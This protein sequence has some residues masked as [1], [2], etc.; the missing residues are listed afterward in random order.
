M[1]AET[2]GAP[3]ERRASTATKVSANLT[4]ESLIST[5]THNE[6]LCELHEKHLNLRGH[7]TL[8]PESIPDP[9]FLEAYAT[10]GPSFPRYIVDLDDWEE[11]GSGVEQGPP[12]PEPD[13]PPEALRTPR[14]LGAQG[15]PPQSEEERRAAEGEVPALGPAARFAQAVVT[16]GPQSL[17]TRAQRASRALQALNREPANSETQ[18]DFR[19]R[20]AELKY[21]ERGPLSNPKDLAHAEA[22]LAAVLAKRRR[23]ANAQAAREAHRREME[24]ALGLALPDE[25]T[26]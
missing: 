26:T 16:T 20:L 15:W 22:V 10:A 2:A 18:D 17:P 19:E 21:H 14:G 6:R 12:E 3:L 23:Q 1:T 4:T 13:P 11:M 5:L 24:K 7:L 8:P 9:M 25:S